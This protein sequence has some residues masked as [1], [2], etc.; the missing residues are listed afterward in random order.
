MECLTHRDCKMFMSDRTHG[1]GGGVYVLVSNCLP[2]IAI[3][4]NLLSDL[5]SDSNTVV[6][7]DR[8][9]RPNIVC[10]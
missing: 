10:I 6:S 2:L 9:Y 4:S 5:I 8:V 1:R 3:H 7:D